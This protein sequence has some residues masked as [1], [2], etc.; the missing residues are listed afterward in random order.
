MSS[1]LFAPIKPEVPFLSLEIFLT[2]ECDPYTSSLNITTSLITLHI[3]VCHIFGAVT[4]I[5]LVLWA[6][7]SYCTQ[8]VSPLG[9][10]CALLWSSCKGTQWQASFWY[11]AEG[12]GTL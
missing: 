6:G 12:P 9:A 7:L 10:L 3:F 4:W 11:Y 2:N 1:Y 8:I 5:E